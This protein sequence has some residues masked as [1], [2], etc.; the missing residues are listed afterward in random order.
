M[1]HALWPATA[2][3]ISEVCRVM[4]EKAKE[5]GMSNSSFKKPH[6][7]ESTVLFDRGR[8]GLLTAAAMKIRILRLLWQKRKQKSTE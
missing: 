6:G 1:P 5:L 8:Y 3:G 7:L 2:G 4:N